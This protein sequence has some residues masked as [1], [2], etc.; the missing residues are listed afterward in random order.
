MVLPFTT[1]LLMRD[2]E[3]VPYTYTP[4]DPPSIKLLRMRTSDTV[5]SLSRTG[6]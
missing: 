3:F 6:F 2:V 1:T 4:Q 5:A